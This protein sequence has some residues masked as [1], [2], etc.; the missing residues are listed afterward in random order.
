MKNNNFDFFK[1]VVEAIIFS[2]SQPVRIDYLEKKVPSSIN[3]NKIL[4]NSKK[5]TQKGE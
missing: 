4:N 1:N 2:S 3:L 5:I